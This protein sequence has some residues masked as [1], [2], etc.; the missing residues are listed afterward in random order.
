[1]E[2]FLS[3]TSCRKIATGKYILKLR[4][5]LCKLTKQNLAKTM[6]SHTRMMV[7]KTREYQIRELN[8]G[9]IKGTTNENEESDMEINAI[10]QTIKLNL[11]LMKD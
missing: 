5:I 2:T 6:M 8:M 3:L 9:M 4:V 11:S 1:M 7:R 10:Q